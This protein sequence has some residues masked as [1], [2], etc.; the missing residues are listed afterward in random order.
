MKNIVKFILFVGYT[1]GIFC[2][3]DAKILCGMILLNSSIT[4]LLKIDLKKMLHSVKIFLPFVA[5]TVALNLLLDSLQEAILIGIR[6]LICYHATYLFSQT[7]TTLEIADTVQKICTPLKLFGID[8]K[9]IGM[10]ISISICMLPVLKNEITT[11]MQAMQA[12]GMPLNIKNSNILME[13]MFISIFRKTNE[14]EK[15]LLSK[16]YRE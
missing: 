15:T 13:P 6:I 10:M 11:V 14:M 5:I 7:L 4:I 3:K 8:T 1:I 2:V 9:H 12:K 16:A